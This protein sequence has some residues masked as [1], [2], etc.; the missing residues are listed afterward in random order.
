MILSDPVDLNVAPLH[1]LAVSLYFPGETGPPTTHSIGLHPAYIKEG[2][3]TGQA[4]M[5]DAATAQSYY[6]LEASTSLAPAAA[7]LIVA[8]GDSITDGA[9]LHPGHQSQLARAAG[10]QAGG[11]EGDGQHR[12]GTWGSAATGSCAT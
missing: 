12:R 2:D 8:F 9:P 5:P 3:V 10:G 6:W 4:A 1:D 11:T 7:A